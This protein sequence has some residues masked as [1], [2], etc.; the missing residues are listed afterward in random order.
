MEVPFYEDELEDN[1]QTSTF[2]WF[3][4]MKDCFYALAWYYLW[5][6]NVCVWILDTWIFHDFKENFFI[7]E[8]WHKEATYDELWSK[9]FSL[10]SD[11]TMN[12]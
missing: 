1:G 8:F 6:D 2:V 3:R 4:S 7:W 10:G 12:P 11:W 9:G 5:V